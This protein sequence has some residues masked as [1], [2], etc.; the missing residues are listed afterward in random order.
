M[1][2]VL[3]EE[4]HGAEVTV[5]KETR[6]TFTGRDG[7]LIQVTNI[8]SHTLGVVLWNEDI[9]EEYVYPMIKKMTQIPAQ[10]IN[11]FGTAAANMKEVVVRV[12]EG[13]STVPAECTPL[14]VCRVELPPFLPKGSPVE[15]TYRWDENQTLQVMVDAFGKQSK[16]E[17]NRNS[18]LSD[19]EIAAAQASLSLL[20][21][22]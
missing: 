18:A 17:I 1:L 14:G 2:C 19:E 3:D 12:F 10:T 15:L 5:S 9:L 20:K 6:Q 4:N 22:E 11:S 16:V 21:V 13:E 8:T 7:G